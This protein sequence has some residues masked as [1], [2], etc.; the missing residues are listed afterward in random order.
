[1]MRPGT[2]LHADE[3]PRQ[4]GK[5]GFNLPARPLLAQHQGSTPILADDVERVLADIDAD[6]V[7]LAIEYLGHGILLCLRCPCQ[8]GSLAGLEHGRTIPFSDIRHAAQRLVRRSAVI[9]SL[10]AIMKAV[11]PEDPCDP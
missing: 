5:P 10:L 3:A 7:D 8:F 2:S 11:V 6:H 1:M 4:I 9:W